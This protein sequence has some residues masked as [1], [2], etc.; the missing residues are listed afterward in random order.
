MKPCIFLILLVLP[1]RV[2]AQAPVGGPIPVA[3][4]SSEDFLRDPDVAMNPRGDFVVGWVRGR[5][6]N[7]STAVFGR[8][9]AADGSPRT[10]E[11]RLDR[12]AGRATAVRLAMMDDGSFVAVFPAQGV[13]L[14]RRFTSAGTPLGGTLTVAQ[15]LVDNLEVGTRGDGSFVV[16]W[17]GIFSGTFARA[18]DAGGHPL[19]PE[20]PVVLARA[21]RPRLA[22]RPD[23]SFLVV[24]VQLE[25]TGPDA[26]E[27]FLQGRLFGADGTPRGESFPISDKLSEDLF[28]FSGYDTAVDGDGN[29]L[30]T[31][32][33]QGTDLNSPTAWVRRYAPDG[34]PLS[35]PLLAGHRPAGQEIATGPDGRFVSI[36]QTAGRPPVSIAVREFAEDGAPAGPLTVLGQISRQTVPGPDLTG[37]GAGNFVAAWIDDKPGPG[38]YTLFARRFRTD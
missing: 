19:G 11:F 34:S 22:V 35:G 3:V 16:T 12:S 10:R 4:L 15:S 14:A 30:V 23:G 1:A 5:A 18:F 24:W 31:W 2:F 6:H 21:G 8:L 32:F 26:H 17:E 13:L 27:L 9:Y 38:G 37:D 33:N 28:P 36:W 20:V 25:T 29:F 7:A